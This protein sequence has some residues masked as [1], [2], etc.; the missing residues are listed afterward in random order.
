MLD[1]NDLISAT[2]TEIDTELARILKL[3]DEAFAA[4]ARVQTRRKRRAKLG[5][6]DEPGKAD[7]D[8]VA[9]KATIARCLKESEP[10]EAEFTRR[11]GWTRAY[12]VNNTNGHVHRTMQCRTCYPTTEFYWITDLSGAD[13]DYIVG[14]AGEKACTECYPSAPVDVLR[15]PTRIKT[16]EQ[17]ARL[18]EKAA[19]A[20]ANAVKAI[21]APDGGPLRTKRDGTIR[22][23]VSARRAYADVVAYA[24]Y[25]RATG[26]TDRQALIAECEHDAELILAA[27]AAKHAQSVEDVRAELAG[28]VDRRW[29]RE[30]GRW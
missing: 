18:A 10:L 1:A 7:P 13:E 4:I 9:A 27:L 20:T 28:S 2:P 22:T 25:L 21:T 14:E 15:R 8:V 12:L 11:G 26:S 19:R 16:P 23:E 17:V 24:R 3:V 29:K 5:Y 6:A 30:Y